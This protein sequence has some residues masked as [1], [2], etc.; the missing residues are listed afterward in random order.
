MTGSEEKHTAGLT[1]TLGRRN[2]VH[3]NRMCAQCGADFRPKRASSAYCSRPCA[4]KM[5]G[6]HNRK[7]ECWWTNGRGYIEGRVN[8]VRKKQHRHVMEVA[9]GRA[10]RPDEDV[11]HKDGNKTNNDPSNLEILPHGE[12]ARVTNA[13]RTYRRGYALVLTDEERRKRAE[14]LRRNRTPRTALPAISLATQDPDQGKG[15]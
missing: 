1:D 11:H 2:R 14:T 15:E 3:A 12:H 13:G 4:W 8:G 9:L 6:G 5:N 7:S 10:L